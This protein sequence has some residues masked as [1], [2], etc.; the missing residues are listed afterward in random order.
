MDANMRVLIATAGSHGDVL[1]F[2]ALGQEMLD[3]GHDVIFYANPFFEKYLRD[4][5]I[6]FIPIGTIEEYLAVWSD[7]NGKKPFKAFR[8]VTRYFL[9]ICLPYYKAMKQDVLV[10]ETITIGHPLMF[11][12]R[13]LKETHDVPTATIHLAPVPFRSNTYPSKLLPIW[14][15]P[16]MP[17]VVKNMAWSA[18]DHLYFD[19][20]VNKPFNEMRHLI[21]LKP[22]RKVFRGWMTDADAVIGMFPQWFA[23][24]QA[25]WST[26]VHFAGF[27]Q[28]AHGSDEHLPEDVQA[29][30]DAG[31]APILFTAGTASAMAED[32]FETSIKACVRGKFRGILLTPF[33]NQVPAH[34]PDGIVHYSFVPYHLLLPK[35]AAIVHHGGI[36]TTSLALHAG[37]PQLI[38][39]VAYDQ[40]DN[41]NRVVN[42]LG[43]GKQLLPMSYTP[44]VVA[45][46]LKKLVND[47]KVLEH[48]RVYAKN[49]SHES[50]AIKNACDAILELGVIP[51]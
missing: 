4:S 17:K 47:V 8:H 35:L 19:H 18:M 10:G 48:C 37:I 12:T 6:K 34:L 41:A 51:V 15:T 25:D 39:P 32:F 27:P 38:R 44:T 36:G 46:V 50:D 45:Y 9:N 49:L 42:L 31:D 13:F 21:G 24:P 43:V 1:P 14:I 7:T 29:F 40:F 28:N 22:L 23:V 2:I 5:R 20:N 11:S 30:L 33:N 3:R 26:K 16:K